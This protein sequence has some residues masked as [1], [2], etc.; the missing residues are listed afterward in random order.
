MSSMTLQKETQC[1][2]AYLIGRLRGDPYAR[3]SAPT[4]PLLHHHNPRLVRHALVEVDDVLVHQA[5]AA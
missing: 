2:A 5:H 4:L 1:R 3:H